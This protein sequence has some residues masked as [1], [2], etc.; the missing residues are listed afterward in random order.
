MN[1]P[2][3]LHEADF[4]FRHHLPLHNPS[5]PFAPFRRSFIIVFRFTSVLAVVVGALATTIRQTKKS[6]SSIA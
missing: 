2:L 6:F 4:P 5:C 3:S 1:I